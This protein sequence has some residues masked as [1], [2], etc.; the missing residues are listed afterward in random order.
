MKQETY[1]CYV[2]GGAQPPTY[3]VRQSSS[4]PRQ[5]RLVQTDL[6]LIENVV[7]EA[8]R[9]AAALGRTRYRITVD[10]EFGKTVEQSPRPD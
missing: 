6:L 5:C 2:D 10:R 4:I 9:H 7:M 1:N 3:V 8:M